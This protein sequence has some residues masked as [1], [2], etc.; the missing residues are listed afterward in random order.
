[1]HFAR[2]VSLGL[3]G[4]VVLFSS[5]AGWS[6]LQAD[7]LAVAPAMQEK[8][9]KT[10]ADGVKYLRTNQGADG[11]WAQP[12]E[13]FKIG[14]T[15]LPGLTLLEC[16]AAADD[17]VVLRAARLVRASAPRLEETYEIA[18][19]ILFLDRLGDPKDRK[20]V[21]SL[22]LRLIAG[23]T[24]TGG[25]TYRC[26]RLLVAQEGQLL[27][28]L[29]QLSPDDVFRPTL[30]GET[31]S[32]GESPGTLTPSIDKTEPEKP[33][34][35][36]TSPDKGKPSP[37][38]I[39]EAKSNSPEG[40][41]KER[42]GPPARSLT[43]PVLCIKMLDHPPEPGPAVPAKVVEPVKP[44]AEGP[45]VIPP[46]FQKL[47]VLNDP[48]KLQMVDPEQK[49]FD[50]TIGTTD[51][52]NTQFAMLAIWAARRYEIPTRR[53]LTL[54]TRRFHTS[55][56]HDGGWNYYYKMGGAA[57]ELRGPAMTCVGLLGLAIA[58][59]LAND[60]ADGNPPPQG[61]F[62]PGKRVPPDARIVNGF[63]A[64]QPFLG[65]PQ[66]KTEGIPNNN[67]Y[68]LWSVERVAV[69]YGLRT[70]GP[71]DWYRWGAEVL[72]SNQNPGGHW[73]KG[74]YHGATPT[75]NTCLALLFLKRVNLAGDLKGKLAFQAEDLSATLVTRAAPKKNGVDPR[76]AV[77]A[78]P[79]SDPP[80]VTPDLPA[81]TPAPLART[82][83]E[84]EDSGASGGRRSLLS[85]LLPVVV[86]VVVLVGAG[87]VLLVVYKRESAEAD[88]SARKSTKSRSGKS[89]KR[90]PRPVP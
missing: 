22:A 14:Y 44:V 90:R 36:E 37:G 60:Q 75:I 11:S 52:S 71:K 18:L 5:L 34:P 61:A 10:I 63:L 28:I 21:Q 9:N 83:T 43:R 73:E 30:V 17:P 62:G 33:S 81:S 53:T 39:E 48:D 67:L 35:G 2:K 64:L 26:P 7:P 13:R 57:H 32:P 23:Q 50:P 41:P 69:L 82:T 6:R 66:G 87:V 49:A 24:A 47:P 89:G 19:S 85:W 51:N 65:E 68:Y 88:R 55:Q 15:A 25:W 1:M 86:L 59:G 78:P 8:I 76:P 84:T 3:L 12:M 80:A 56:I 4:L 74:N 77:E 40:A 72:V 16:G 70:I 46:M 58:H 42:S 38:E 20:L 29:R 31:P 79:R 54:I 27:R 45:L